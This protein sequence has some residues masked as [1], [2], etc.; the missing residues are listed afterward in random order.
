MPPSNLTELELFCKEEWEKISV[1]R[2][3]KL[4]ETYPKRLTAVIA[5]KSGKP[6]AGGRKNRDRLFDISTHPRR[7]VALRL[8]SRRTQTTLWKPGSSED[9]TDPGSPELA[10][11]VDDEVKN[12]VDA[13]EL[14]YV[15][16]LNR[17]LPQDTRTL[18]WSPAVERFSACCDLLMT[19]A[20]KRYEGTHDFRNLCKEFL[21]VERN[22]R[23][24]MYS[25]VVDFP[26]VLFHCHFEVLSWCREAEE[27]NHSLATLQQHWTQIA[28]KTQI[29]I[30]KIPTYFRPLKTTAKHILFIYTTTSYF[31]I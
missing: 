2:C 11:H 27:V 26:L 17:V 28:V 14:P 16:M 23:K 7:H 1:S 21:D 12:K 8:L 15:K 29:R 5:A 24:T 31:F 20:A 3:A 22:P 30:N 25:T 10:L 18:D 9:S 19:A 13:A 4:I 6:D